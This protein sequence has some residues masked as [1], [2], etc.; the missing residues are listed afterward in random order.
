MPRHL[1][2]S[3]RYDLGAR[4]HELGDAAEALSMYERAASLPPSSSSFSSSS[5]TLLLIAP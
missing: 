2:L 1:T 5:L 4:A 3:L